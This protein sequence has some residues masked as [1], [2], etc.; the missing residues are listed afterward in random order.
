M[1]H[2]A[3]ELAQPDA[4]VVSADELVGRAVEPD[5]DLALHDFAEASTDD[6]DDD[7][8]SERLRTGSGSTLARASYYLAPCLL[9]L[10]GEIDARWPDRDRRSDGWIGDPSHAARTSDHNPDWSAGGVVRALDID[11]DGI[12]VRQLL[13]EV[14]GD[15]RVWYVIHAHTIYSRTYDWT[16]RA[17]T[18]TNPHTTHLHISILHSR[19]AEE[20]EA[21]WFGPR[22]RPRTRGLPVVDLSNVR[23]Q[24]QRGGRQPLVGVKRIQRA[25]NARYGARLVVDGYAG[26]ATRRAFRRHERLIEAPQTDGIPGSFSLTE[27][28]RG[29][30]RVVK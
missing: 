11:V 12:R 24:F 10:R 4:E 20:D 8:L 29:R 27:L 22:K 17:Y 23:A 28:A 19:A 30:F 7:R 6:E 5:H 14:I 21:P 9:A 13:T 3:S 2:D 16:A 26:D 18:G 15:P 25:L 1:K